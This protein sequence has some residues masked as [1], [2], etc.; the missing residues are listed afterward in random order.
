MKLIRTLLSS[1]F[2][3]IQINRVLQRKNSEIDGKLD[4]AARSFGLE[5]STS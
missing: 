5:A 4:L 3:N 2:L 1:R